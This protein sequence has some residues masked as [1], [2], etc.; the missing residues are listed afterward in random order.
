M[1]SLVKYVSSANTILNTKISYCWADH[2]LREHG[3]LHIYQKAFEFL[4]Q[5]YPQT[6]TYITKYVGMFCKPS[7]CFPSKFCKKDILERDLG[8]CGFYFSK[9]DINKATTLYYCHYFINE[10][11]MPLKEGH[12]KNK[13]ILVISWGFLISPWTQHTWSHA[14]WLFSRP[15]PGSHSQMVTGNRV[16]GCWVLL[17]PERLREMHKW[18][19]GCLAVPRNNWSYKKS[20]PPNLPSY[21]KELNVHNPC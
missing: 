2:F 7:K 18:G 21:Q 9:K 19:A 13:I 14:L 11:L 8:L 15:A 5:F 20:C 12:P 1:W 17:L 4:D 6:C 10:I 16:L 3:P